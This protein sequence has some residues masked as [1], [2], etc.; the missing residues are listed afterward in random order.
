MIKEVY[1]G[2][3]FEHYFI[4]PTPVHTILRDEIG[5]H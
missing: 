1:G 2:T 5:I 3:G 4:N